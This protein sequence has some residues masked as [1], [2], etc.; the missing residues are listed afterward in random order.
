MQQSSKPISEYS[1]VELKS[2]G[3]DMMVEIEL[4]NKN[5]TIIQNELNRR[6]QDVKAKIPQDEMNKII[7]NGEFNL[8]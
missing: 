5:L 3:F 7:Q 2:F 8:K 6:K 1:D 4:L